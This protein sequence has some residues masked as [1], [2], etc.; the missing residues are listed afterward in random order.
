MHI[1]QNLS[2]GLR[3]H[4]LQRVT[5]GGLSSVLASLFLRPVVYIMVGILPRGRSSFSPLSSSQHRPPLWRPPSVGLLRASLCFGHLQASLSFGLPQASSSHLEGDTGVLLWQR[6]LLALA[7]SLGSILIDL[8]LASSHHLKGGTGVL[9]RQRSPSALWFTQPL[10]AS[11]L[12]P[13]WRP[14]I[15]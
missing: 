12:P 2:A 1:H 11:R 8:A 4:W 13:P 5:A 6:K 9:L 7:R 14:P 10:S 15:L 3:Q